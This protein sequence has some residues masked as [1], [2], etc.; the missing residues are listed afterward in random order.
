MLGRV[1]PELQQDV[2][3]FERGIGGELAAPKAFFRLL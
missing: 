3:G 2:I 1:Q